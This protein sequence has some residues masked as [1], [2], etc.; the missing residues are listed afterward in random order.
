MV[1][2]VILPLTVKPVY[3]G[4]LYL[5]A[6]SIGMPHILEQYFDIQLISSKKVPN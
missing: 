3:E 4:H 2:H 5:K 6:T 1:E